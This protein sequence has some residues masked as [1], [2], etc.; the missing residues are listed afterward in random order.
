MRRTILRT[1]AVGAAVT[2][3]ARRNAQNFPVSHRETSPAP[4]THYQLC[5]RAENDDGASRGCSWET[6]GWHRH[7]HDGWSAN[8]ADLSR[9]PG[10]RT[11]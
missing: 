6:A 3:P 5:I 8:K 2:S 10:L 7:G 9:H 1:A 4:F 11:A